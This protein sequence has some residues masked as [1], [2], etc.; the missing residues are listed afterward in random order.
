MFTTD[1][2]TILRTTQVDEGYTSDIQTIDGIKNRAYCALFSDNGHMDGNYRTEMLQ[3]D[4]DY[5]DFF[6]TAFPLHYFNDEIGIETIPRWKIAL[7]AKIYENAPYMNSIFSKLDDQIFANYRVRKVENQNASAKVSHLDDT[8]T[9]SS[10]VSHEGEN[11][12]NSTSSAIDSYNDTNAGQHS[13]VLSDNV[14]NTSSEDT[15]GSSSSLE[16][17]LSTT[18]HQGL[19]SVEGNEHSTD[20]NSTIGTK[21]SHDQKV[22]N[23]T[24]AHGESYNG[25]IHEEV[26]DFIEDTEANRDTTTHTIE[27]KIT[28]THTPEGKIQVKNERQE[29]GTYKDEISFQ[30]RKDIATTD[31]N[32]VGVTF[33]TPMGK[34]TSSQNAPAMRT[35]DISKGDGVTAANGSVYNY[36][37]AASESDTSV[38]AEN[39]SKGK[40]IHTHDGN[41]YKVTDTNTTE[42]LNNYKTKDEKEWSNDYEEETTHHY[43]KDIDTDKTDNS[44][45]TSTDVTHGNV[46]DDI[47]ETNN[48]ASAGTN[49]K[50]SSQDTT[51]TYA[52]SVSNEGSVTTTN[53]GSKDISGTTSKATADNGS[54]SSSNAHEGT[55]SDASTSHDTNSFDETSA[56][57]SSRIAI[58]V[59]TKQDNGTIEETDKT[60]S[61]EMILLADGLMNKIWN[62]F[63]DLFMQIIDVFP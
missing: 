11:I 54:E 4:D 5:R 40:E 53:S 37:S 47:N 10:V 50:D 56:G 25:A 22:D 3:I 26:D 16:D 21:V 57:A 48:T 17:K 46:T 62:I 9:R 18:S 2:A 31:S 51:E 27:G 1:M 19:V 43:H 29:T 36:M 30:D 44:A 41:Q 58:D 34:I 55:R 49:N 61:M 6:A 35:T 23:T 38:K 14:V 59:D 33:D 32:G 45:K 7:M 52:D 15:S 42:Y 28:D 63:D 39:E 24:N 8:A 60:Y 13:N 12:N 20:T